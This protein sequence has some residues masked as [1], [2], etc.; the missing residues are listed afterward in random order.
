LTKLTNMIYSI[1]REF[2]TDSE[3]KLLQRYKSCNC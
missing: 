3:S 2:I 1:N